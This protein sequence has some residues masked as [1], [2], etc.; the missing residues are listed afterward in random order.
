[1]LSEEGGKAVA[2]TASTAGNKARS[3]AT[4]NQHLSLH[5]GYLV[6]L[7]VRCKSSSPARRPMSG[8]AQGCDCNGDRCC[9]QC[10]LAATACPICQ[11]RPDCSQLMNHFTASLAHS[12]SLPL[13]RSTAAC[14][15]RVWRK[16]IMHT[17][18]ILI[19][20]LWMSES[21][22]SMVLHVG[23]LIFGLLC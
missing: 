16:L 20:D 21:Q 8:R 15:N 5:F 17:S 13:S 6:K 7:H 4:G 23:V 14:G 12:P 18:S 9:L 19:R 22:Q 3:T 1:M 2:A 10:V 11:F